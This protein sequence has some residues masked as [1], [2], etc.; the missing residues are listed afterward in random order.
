MIKITPKFS[1]RE[2]IDKTIQRN[3]FE[4]QAET[5]ELGTKLHKYM[6][7]YILANSKRQ[8]RT[9]N[10][11]RS[12]NIDKETTAGTIRWGIGNLNIL[13]QS[14]P[15]FYVVNYGKKITG[16][17]FIPGGKKYR[18]VLFTDGLAD[19]DKRGFGTNRV[20]GLK[21]I[22]ETNEPIPNSI[23]P[24]NYIEYTRAQLDNEIK[25]ILAKFKRG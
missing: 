10:L 9:G 16:E 11:A 7:S 23:R 1:T 12:I 22:T 3:W 17:E 18:P 2:I 25:I 14:A 21:R 19:P 20:T 4:F 24:M 13:R 5:F 6:R 15:Y 8:G